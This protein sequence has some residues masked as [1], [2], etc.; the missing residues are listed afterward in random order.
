MWVDVRTFP[1]L[2]GR[3][4][5]RAMNIFS[6]TYHLSASHDSV[7]GGSTTPL[8]APL[9]E[10]E[11]NACVRTSDGECY[12]GVHRQAV[13]ALRPRVRIS[14]CTG[15]KVRKRSAVLGPKRGH[16]VARQKLGGTQTVMLRVQTKDTRAAYDRATS[17][18]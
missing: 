14:V 7:L 10:V 4:L 8:L 3:G 1:G 13:D 16:S 15:Y 6:R 12:G 18:L 17:G 11:A 9:R 5:V 2:G